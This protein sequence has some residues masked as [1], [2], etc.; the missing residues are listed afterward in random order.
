MSAVAVEALVPAAETE[1]PACD[2]CGGTATRVLFVARDLR[3]R[4]P[5]DFPLVECTTCG[6][7]YV[8]PRPI[9]ST[10]ARWYPTSYKAHA[11]H[12]PSVWQ[13]LGQFFEEKIWNSYLRLFLTRS[14]PIF[15]FPR[16]AKELAP[17]GRA[18]R[19]L[20]VGCGP[21]D[22]L[23]YIRRHSSFETFGT[24]FSPQAVANARA[25]GAGDI[26]LRDGHTVPFD[27]GFFDAA[28]SW[29]SLE[30]HYSPRETMTEVARVL[31]PGGYGIFAVP[32]GNNLG[33][34]TF[35]R[36]WGP[37]EIPRHLYY[38]TE[39][40]LRRLLDE[41]GLEVVRVYQD[42][43]F[44]GLF[45]D[46]EIIDSVRWAIRDKLGWVGAPLQLPL[47]ILQFEGLLSSAMTLPLV[48][49]NPLLG[50]LW[51]GSNMIVHF[52]RPA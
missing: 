14:Y 44:Y 47:A 19:I 50:R 36:Y 46:Q 52:R 5:G 8:T 31:R 26:R 11:E 40:T 48:P 2:L 27:D 21:G 7:R 1:A 6:L 20:D 43:S 37:L 22:K 15:Y 25:R 17:A 9:A 29:H 18:P 13:R 24:D 45:L 28:M 10:I 35:G 33:L 42:I 12:K 34:R 51:R 23:R 38:F 49:L 4:I 16:H 3:Y 41:V 39:A 32:S 30:H